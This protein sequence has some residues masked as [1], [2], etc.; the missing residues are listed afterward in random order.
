M[1]DELDLYFLTQAEYE[2]ALM[3]EHIMEESLYQEDDQEGYNLRSRIVAPVKESPAPTKK[4]APP[5]K[6]IA[7]T[8]NKMDAP[9]KQSKI[10]CSH[11]FMIKSISR[12][13]LKR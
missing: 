3:N 1:E 2:E 5:A 11:L 12:L 10:H 8:T 6:N 4:P 9:S 13:H 7:A